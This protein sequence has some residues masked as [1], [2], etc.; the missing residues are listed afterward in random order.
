[1]RAYIYRDT[2]GDF[3]IVN[4]EPRIDPSEYLGDSG[5]VLHQALRTALNPSKVE[6]QALLETVPQGEF[7]RIEISVIPDDEVYL[8]ERVE[9]WAKQRREEAEFNYEGEEEC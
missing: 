2:L 1:M 4:D 3:Y 5:V 7:R 6:R 9:R 8:T